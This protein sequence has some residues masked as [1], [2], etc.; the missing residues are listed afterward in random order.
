MHAKTSAIFLF[1]VLSSHAWESLHLPCREDEDLVSLLLPLPR[2]EDEDWVSLPLPRSEDFG[3]P[4]NS[5]RLPRSCQTFLLGPSQSLQFSS[6]AEERKVGLAPS[7]VCS[8][9][10]NVRDI[11]GESRSCV[12]VYLVDRR[13]QVEGVTCWVQ[14]IESRM[15]NYHEGCFAFD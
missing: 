12:P 15:K 6:E 9:L 1:S 7:L 10:A 8:R 11:S 5:S 13:N 3:L 4:F 2:S 14:F